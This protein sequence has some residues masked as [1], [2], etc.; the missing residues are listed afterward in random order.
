MKTT[1]YTIAKSMYEL[2]SGVRQVNSNLPLL[3]GYFRQS[4]VNW[5]CWHKGP[6]IFNLDS[7]L[8][9]SFAATI[10][11]IF[12]KTCNYAVR[13]LKTFKYSGFNKVDNGKMTTPG[14]AAHAASPMFGYASLVCGLTCVHG[15]QSG[16]TT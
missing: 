13:Y 5:N 15:A 16:R 8:K 11:E 10:S 1:S 3:L 6:L 7:K 14:P 9:H 2:Y 4:A 12:Y